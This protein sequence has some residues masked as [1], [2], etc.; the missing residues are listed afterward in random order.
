MVDI[1]A[2]LMAA[3]ERLGP[4]GRAL[5]SAEGAPVR[6]LPLVGLEWVRW[7]GSGLYEPADDGDPALVVAIRQDP[8]SPDHE[9]PDPGLAVIL[10]DLVD[11][12]AFE[13]R[14]PGRIAIRLGLADVLGCVLPQI[15]DPP[16]TRIRRSPWTWLLSGGRGLV[17]LGSEHDRYRV[18][19]SL[20]GIVAE[21]L[22]HARELKAIVERPFAAPPVLVA[23][24]G[25]RVA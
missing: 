25:R 12:V 3:R 18:L 19:S 21:D 10:G 2:E 5:L 17:L 6:L 23:D 20:A 22:P 1:D 24:R 11:L 14:P 4:E 7:C 15:F 16:P 9:S 13:P 8:E